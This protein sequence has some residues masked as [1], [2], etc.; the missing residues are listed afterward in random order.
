MQLWLV[1]S[2]QGQLP[3][4]NNN[5]YYEEP[6]TVYQAFLF[7]IGAFCQTWVRVVFFVNTAHWFME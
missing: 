1:P 2:S 5:Y 3:Y 6:L 7:H 4:N